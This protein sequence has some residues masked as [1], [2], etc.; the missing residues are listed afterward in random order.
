MEDIADMTLMCQTIKK[1]RVESIK[2]Q[3]NWDFGSLG[4]IGEFLSGTAEVTGR[5]LQ[6]VE[7]FPNAINATAQ[8]V[9]KMVLGTGTVA[10]DVALGTG[11]MGKDIILGTGKVGYGVVVGSGKVATDVVLGTGRVVTTGVTEVAKGSA[12]LVVGTGKLTGDLIIGTGKG[13]GKVGKRM[14]SIFS[15]GDVVKKSDLKD[16]KA[17]L[18]H[19]DR[20]ALSPGPGTSRRR[21]AD[22]GLSSSARQLNTSPKHSPKPSPTQGGAKPSLG[23]ENDLREL[24]E[25]EKFMNQLQGMDPDQVKKVLRKQRDQ[26]KA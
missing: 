21:Y 13:I 1:Q 6:L 15:L 14:S 22:A 18:Q 2:N 8:G 4:N 23:L 24:E 17:R 9:G 12:A 5:T 7:F 19:V 25:M 11:R 20:R 10:K 16:R 26:V 3:G